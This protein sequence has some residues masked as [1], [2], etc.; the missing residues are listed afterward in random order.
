MSF[1]FNIYTMLSRTFFFAASLLPFSE[2]PLLY[3]IPV[4]AVRWVC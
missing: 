3:H 2:T 1:S 4:F